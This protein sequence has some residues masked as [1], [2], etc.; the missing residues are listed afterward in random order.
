MDGEKLELLT[1]GIE[2][3]LASFRDSLD[4][5]EGTLKPSCLLNHK[6]YFWLSGLAD[7]VRSSHHK[8]DSQMDE[9]WGFL[10]GAMGSQGHMVQ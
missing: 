9:W 1:K 5:R 6:L 2:M 10:C 8:S 3:A 4:M 7:T